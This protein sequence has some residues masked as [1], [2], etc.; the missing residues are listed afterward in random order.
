MNEQKNF[1]KKCPKI[2]KGSDQYK[3][4]EFKLQLS[5]G[6]TSAVIKEIFK[7]SNTHASSEFSNYAKGSIVLESFIETGK[8]VDQNNLQK[9]VQKGFDIN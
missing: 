7:I 8:L 6:T 5:L 1:L 9:V 4:V 2:E 3:V